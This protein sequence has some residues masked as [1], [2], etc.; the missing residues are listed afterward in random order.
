MK[1]FSK[2]LI[3]YFYSRFVIALD[4]EGRVVCYDLDYLL[5]V[6]HFGFNGQFVLF[7]LDKTTKRTLTT[8]LADIENSSIAMRSLMGKF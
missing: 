6:Y 7:E 5:P 1:I 4:D 3:I 2:F 8:D